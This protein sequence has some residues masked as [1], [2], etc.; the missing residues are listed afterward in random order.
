MG[1]Y[2]TKIVEVDKEKPDKKA[3]KGKPAKGAPKGARK[4]GKDFQIKIPGL[5][6][7]RQVQG[8]DYFHPPVGDSGGCRSAAFARIAR[9]G[10]AG[11][12]RHAA[13]HHWQAGDLH[14]RRQHFLGRPG[15]ASQGF[16][17]ALRQ[18]GQGRRTRRRAGS[19]AQPLV[20]IHGKG[21]KN[22]GKSHRRHVLSRRRH[23]RGRGDH[24][25]V[26]GLRNSSV[27]DSVL[28]HVGWRATS[29][30]HS[31]CAGLFASGQRP[32]LRDGWRLYPCGNWLSCSWCAPKSAA[33]F[34]TR[35]S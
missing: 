26:D 13:G 5:S 33:A 35:S 24:D 16:Q 28:R 22:Q 25:S 1:F 12:K 3:D 4:K 18:H 6:G 11:E 15:A 30:V 21:P 27:R 9:P 23:G 2:P 17:P 8:A 10:E 34:S 19:R 7:A 32:F 29:R 31:L 14:R 20:G